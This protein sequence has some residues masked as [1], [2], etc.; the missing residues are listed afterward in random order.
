M[1][2]IGNLLLTIC[3]IIGCL[4]AATAY[5]ARTSGDNL[6]GL[7]LSDNA[8]DQEM[9]A[10]ERAALRTRYES[11]ELTAE[12]YA[13]A[14]TADIPVV[15]QATEL[16]DSEI[17]EIRDANIE[18]VHSKSFSIARWPYAWVF[19]LSAAG[20]LAG[21]LLVRAGDKALIA[22]Q[23]PA[24]GAK[25]AGSPDAAMETIA[26][27]IASLKADLP[28]MASDEDR[29]RAILTRLGELQA[30]AI[31]T[32]VEARAQLV[33]KFGLARYA[34]IMDRFA[35]MERKV[36]RSWSAAADGHLPESM[37][38]LDDAALL[39]PEVSAKL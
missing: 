32:F 9:S 35:A 27:G 1:K 6:A 8:G 12:Q 29:I 4:S 39:A 37:V 28:G 17:E 33:S 5:M 24:E 31:P 25:V 14:L 22:K 7:T 13:A 38:A 18:Y 19:G 20:L 23:Q 2:L 21:S 16:T 10:D 34:E 36:N 15:A 26:Q 11:G 30:D 3:L